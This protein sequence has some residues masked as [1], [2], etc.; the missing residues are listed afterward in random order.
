[1]AVGHKNIVQCSKGG[2]HL[3]QQPPGRHRHH[4]RR[5]RLSRGRRWRRRRERPP[6]PGTGITFPATLMPRLERR[7]DQLH[8]EAVKREQAQFHPPTQDRATRA[9]LSFPPLHP[10]GSPGQATA[11]IYPTI[12]SSTAPS[13]RLTEPSHSPHQS[14][15]PSIQPSPG[16]SPRTEN[17]EP[18]TANR[19]LKRASPARS[20]H[21]SRRHPP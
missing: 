15:H 5:R 18:R 21:S 10:L 4:R 17:R 1:M 20:P 11:P 3:R 7:N 6:S 13:P 19:E 9:A 2:L 12:H 14:N 16:S 8:Q